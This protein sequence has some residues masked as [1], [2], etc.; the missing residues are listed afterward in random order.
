MDLIQYQPLKSSG[1]AKEH[2]SK[3]LANLKIEP[4]LKEAKINLNK[5]NETGHEQ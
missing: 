1:V 3:W 4:A 5:K 2:F